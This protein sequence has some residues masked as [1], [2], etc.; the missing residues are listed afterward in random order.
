MELIHDTFLLTNHV[1]VSRNR[2]EEIVGLLL[3]TKEVKRTE[4]EEI[5]VIL[6]II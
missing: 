5:G 3:V 4:D 1:F 2:E 6:K